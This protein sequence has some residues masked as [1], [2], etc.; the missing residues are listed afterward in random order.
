MTHADLY[1]TARLDWSE[2]PESVRAA[3][4]AVLA[5]EPHPASPT[6]PSHRRSPR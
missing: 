2:E 5:D 6:F 4:D 1:P 3:Y